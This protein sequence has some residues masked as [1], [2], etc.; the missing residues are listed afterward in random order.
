M[1]AF[2]NLVVETGEVQFSNSDEETASLGDHH[3]AP[4]VT[5]SCEDGDFN[6]FIVSVTSSELTIGLS[7]KFTGKVFYHA[8][9][10]R[11]GR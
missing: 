5:L 4:K 11:R 6:P 3:E 2:D 1:S 9:S 7:S 10:T 8:I